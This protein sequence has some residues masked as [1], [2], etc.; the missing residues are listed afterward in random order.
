MSRTNTNG[1]TAR[2]VRA[3]GGYDA[4]FTQQPAAPGDG[5]FAGQHSDSG[6]TAGDPDASGSAPA[7]GST[8]QPDSPTPP[9]M[10]N[11]DSAN[12]HRVHRPWTGRT[13]RNEPDTHETA[14][15]AVQSGPAPEPPGP[16]AA[17]AGGAA[18]RRHPA[19]DPAT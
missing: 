2:T 14:S 15:A 1:D 5:E 7:Q 10:W 8:G 17:Q 18:D 13:A 9:P 16:A 6:M 3:R 12:T 4:Y 11:L 19:S